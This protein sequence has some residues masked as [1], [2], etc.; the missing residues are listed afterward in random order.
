MEDYLKLL[1]AYQTL[2]HTHRSR[3]F[4]D[5]AGYPSRE[6]VCSNI[7]AFYFDPTEEHGLGDLLLTALFSMCGIA[8]DGFPATEQVSV[9]REHYTTNGKRIDLVI[10]HPEFTAGIENKIYHW[11]ANDLDEYSDELNQ[12]GAGKSHILKI[13][14]G[15]HPLRKPLSGDFQSHTYR[16][17][18]EYV[19]KRLGQRIGSLNQKW[20]THLIDFMANTENL[21]GST[22]ELKLNDQFFIDH[23]QLINRMNA[24]LNDFLNRLNRRVEELKQL[25]AESDEGSSLKKLPWVYTSRCLVLDVSLAN[26][27]IVAFDLWLRTSGW[28]LQL[29]GRER[30]HRYALEL[31]DKII[32]GSPERTDN[33]RYVAERWPIDADLG[34]IR[35]ALNNWIS[36]VTTAAN[37][38]QAQPANSIQA[39]LVE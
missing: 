31:G 21:T 27:E 35:N 10:N 33:G 3:T 36:K 17:F 12:M 18:W 26:G 5:V 16:E 19:R 8:E 34:E 13:V 20:L 24:D 11:L 15:L 9:I 25:M 14:L 32:I 28:E 6:N 39:E 1:L 4:M 38:S 22:M 29:F 7:L 2:P 37:E 23:E 30:S